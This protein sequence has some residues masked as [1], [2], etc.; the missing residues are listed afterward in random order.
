MLKMN[1]FVFT[2][3]FFQNTDTN[4][5]NKAFFKKLYFIQKMYHIKHSLIVHL[6]ELAFMFSQDVF[7]ADYKT[8]LRGCL[9][10]FILSYSYKSIYLSERHFPLILSYSYSALVFFP[11]QNILIIPIIFVIYCA[12]FNSSKGSW[13]CSELSQFYQIFNF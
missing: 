3:N 5:H 12:L 13:Q 10:K 2:P 1:L 9:K 11:N 8:H 6:N 7:G 4:K